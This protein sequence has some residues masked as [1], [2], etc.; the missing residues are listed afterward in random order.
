MRVDPSIFPETQFL[1]FLA[2]FVSQEIFLSCLL[3]F[4]GSRSR[5]QGAYVRLTSPDN[6]LAQWPME[7]PFWEQPNV[8]TREPSSYLFIWSETQ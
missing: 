3:S 5:S 8:L 6:D 2:Q 1:Q 7:A 4:L